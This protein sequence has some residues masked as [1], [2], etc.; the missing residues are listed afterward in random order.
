MIM[1]SSLSCNAQIL[2]TMS[3]FVVESKLPPGTALRGGHLGLGLLGGGGMLQLVSLPCLRLS[4]GHGM[5][6][7]QSELD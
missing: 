4:A 7:H 2:Q 6:L 3:L 1:I 5:L